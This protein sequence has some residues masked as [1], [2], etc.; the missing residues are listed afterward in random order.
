MQRIYL[1][2]KFLLT[3]LLLA[4]LPFSA[5]SARFNGY[6]LQFFT[7]ETDHFRINYQKGCDH[8]VGKVGTKLEQLYT[9]YRDTYGLVLPGKTEVVI[10]DSDQSNG[11][12][13]SYTNTITLW[14]HDFDFNLRGSHDWF[15][16]VIT[17]EY[18]HIVSIWASHKLSHYITDVRFGFFT[19]PNE[20]KRVESFHA[21]PTDILPP[22]FTEGIAQY[23]SSRHGADSWDSHRDMI[24]RTLAL[25]GKLLSWDH[26]QV[27][28]G[29]GDDYEKT[30]NHGFSLVSYIS[31]RYG[32]EK[33]L[34]LL[35]ESSK[36]HR[37]SFDRA[38]KNVLGIPAKQLYREWKQY[39]S[40]KYKNQIDSIGPQVFGRKINKQGFENFWP[41]FS[42][43]GNRLFYLSN[44]DREYS[45]T[46]LVQAALSDSV[47]TT[48]MRNP[49]SPISSFYDI[50]APT[51]KFCFVSP[52]EKKSILPP[53]KGGEPVH[54]LFIDKIPSVIKEFKPFAK[55]TERQLTFKKSVFC[56]SFSPQGD[57]I[58]CA[59]RSIDHFSLAIVDTTGE[60]Y[61][62]IYPD[63]QKAEQTIHF[64]YSVN[65]SPD[66]RHIAFSF[67][68]K[69][70]RKIGVFDTLTRT[71]SVI[72]A[73]DN[74]ERD[75]VYS[76]D[77]TFLYFSSDRTGIFNI[78]RYDFGKKSIE[79]VTNVSGGAFAPALSPDGSR[80]AYAGYDK[81]GYGIYLLDT[82]TPL[83]TLEPDSG[84]ITRNPVPKETKIVATSSPRPYQHFPRQFLISPIILAEQLITS[85]KKAQQGKTTVKAGAV[86]NL[87]EP[88]TLSGLGSEL[89]GFFLLEPSQLFNFINLDHG[90]INTRANYDLGLFGY[91]QR[92]PLT[93]SFDYLLRGIADTDEFYDETNEKV[94][95][96]PYNV[97]VQ[98]LNI[99]VSHYISGRY[100]LVGSARNAMVVSLLFGLNTYD[101]KLLL[102]DLYDVGVF[103]Y[104]LAKG[105]R[106][107]ALGSFGTRILESK[108]NIS[109]R[110][111][112][113]RLQYD[114]WNQYSL[115]EE[116]SFA[117]S[118]I[119][120]EQY[121]K[122]LFHQL[123]GRTKLGMAAPWYNKHDIHLDVSGTYL[124]VLKKDTTFPS[125][126]LP[127]AWVPGYSYYYRDVKV[128]D[129]VGEDT[130]RIEY[131]TLLVTGNTI[132][133]GEVSYRF[134]LW[135]GMINKKLW[136]LYFERLYG[137]FHVCGGA[138]WEK[139]S[140]FFNF[141]RHDWLLSY[142]LELRLEAQTFSNLPLALRMR[143]DNGIDK[144]P[145]LGGHRFSFS[146]GFDFDSWSII[147]SPDYNRI[148]SVLQNLNM[149]K[150]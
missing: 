100:D 57:K 50:H 141:D 88:L 87:L 96:L 21:V 41:K 126:Y 118:S 25:S 68:D 137:A 77:G 8:L 29:K 133:T 119:L 143:W 130:I 97:Q 129:I 36:A 3:I 104:N 60:N 5:F 61:T 105:F 47:D 32:Y 31:E 89:G 139:G 106:A 59:Q 122:Y 103:K 26:M 107:G 45:R 66:G 79:Q 48:K 14:T 146:V 58:V 112:V 43:D 80:L 55:K 144:K 12:A 10:L 35:R 109:P 27:F 111:I 56:A 136:F 39:L 95:V 132:L 114:F 54:D 140:D 22:W 1:V 15:E 69:E 82:I 65:W 78:Y 33:I 116:N 138:G 63:P 37:F 91:T 93:L 123:M 147:H 46:T 86:F 62:I 101:V 42:P 4:L 131:D 115:K 85:D 108:M 17:H 74:D 145:P 71:C 13:L 113:A 90:G 125:F 102:E 135:P 127:G 11:W 24:L 19:H 64:I 53:H 110:G 128:K 6:G 81:D 150:F 28:A 18:A 92:L 16:D 7:V 120:K 40:V 149:R 99:L 124:Q 117:E 44:R 49:L 134:P 94:E 98:N 75:P 76:P 23:E 20:P 30:Y 34:A 84:I 9:I 73:T 51:G 67:F 38:I 121:D 72:A 70:N 2:N 148:S 142:G 83:R 52:K